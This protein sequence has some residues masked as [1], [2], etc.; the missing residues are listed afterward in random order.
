MRMNMQTQIKNK[1]FESAL[2]EFIIV[3]ESDG[4]SEDTI[5]D[6]RNSGKPF[7]CILWGKQT[8]KPVLAKKQ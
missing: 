4:L 2:E 7:S 1:T 6:Y 3:K 8:G 5:N